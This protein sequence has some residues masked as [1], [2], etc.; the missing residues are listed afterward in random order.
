MA[1]VREVSI[2]AGKPRRVK[3]YKVLARFGRAVEIRFQG[4]NLYRC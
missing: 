2:L 4:K 1:L 3:I